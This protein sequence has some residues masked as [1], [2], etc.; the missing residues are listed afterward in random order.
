MT[1]GPGQLLRTPESTVGDVDVDGQRLLE[2]VVEDWTKG[3]EDTLERLNT[4]TE[5]KALLT[6][7]KERLLNLGVVL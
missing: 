6:T 1:D 5:V 4:S 7:L 2:P 3:G